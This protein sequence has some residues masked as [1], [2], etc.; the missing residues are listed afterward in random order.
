MLSL[1]SIFSNSSDICLV[2]FLLS[3]FM[4][5]PYVVQYLLVYVSPFLLSGIPWK[6]TFDY[7]VTL[8]SPLAGPISKLCLLRPLLTSHSSLLLRLMGSR[9]RDP[10]GISLPSLSSS[11]CLIYAHR[12]TVCLLDFA[13]VGQL[14]RHV[15][16]ISRFLFVRLRFLLS[17]LLA[18]TS[19]YKPRNR[20]RVRRQLRPLWTFTTD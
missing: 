6:H 10:H 11:T 15:R 3:V 19:R 17:L 4:D 20:Y 16:L 13:V 1:D 5:S 18:C 12:F 8:F 7:T 9:L 14:I 2:C